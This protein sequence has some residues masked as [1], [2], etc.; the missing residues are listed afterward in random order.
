MPRKPPAPT[1]PGELLREILDEHLR[2]PIATAARAMKVS[3]ASLHAVLAGRTALTPLMALR[4]ARLT[5]TSAGL[6]VQMQARLD[7][8]QAEERWGR[9]VSAEVARA[10]AGTRALRS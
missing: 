8:W 3:R 4:F 1:H 10:R 7:L 6:L 2:L 5:G 9:Q